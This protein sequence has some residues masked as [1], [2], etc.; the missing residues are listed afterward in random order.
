MSLKDLI[1]AKIIEKRSKFVDEADFYK[2]LESLDLKIKS[3]AIRNKTRI[4]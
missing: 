4:I 1:I 2:L 3:K